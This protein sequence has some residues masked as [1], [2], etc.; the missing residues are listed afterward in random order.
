MPCLKHFFVRAIPKLLS[1]TSLVS[2]GNSS[3]GNKQISSSG[4]GIQESGWK[5]HS[6]KRDKT[7]FTTTNSTHGE[8]D[9]RFASGKYLE[10]G[11]MGTHETVIGGAYNH[12][13]EPIARPTPPEAAMVANGRGIVKTVGVDVYA[14]TKGP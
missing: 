5:H 1:F 10:L 6:S 9:P 4:G 14:D 11:E 7:P 13:R 3:K 8:I 12:G 2:K